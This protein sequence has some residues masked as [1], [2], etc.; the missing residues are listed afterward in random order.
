[1][2]HRRQDLLDRLPSDIA[3]SDLGPMLGSKDLARLLQCATDPALRLRQLN[4]G[5]ESCVVAAN[6]PLDEAELAVFAAAGATKV[7]LFECTKYVTVSG[8]ELELLCEDAK[9]RM[10]D[11]WRIMQTADSYPPHLLRRRDWY[12]TSTATCRMVNGKLCSSKPYPSGDAR[13]L[14]LGQCHRTG[15]LLLRKEFWR[16][17]R[18]IGAKHVWA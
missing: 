15:Q 18:F 2:A 13:M 6:E 16:D 5:E 17:G 14:Y 3:R 10:I 11:E 4:G 9:N 7:K 8:K 1:M 12:K